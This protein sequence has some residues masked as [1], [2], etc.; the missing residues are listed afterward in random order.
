[1]KKRILLMLLP[2]VTVSLYAEISEAQ[3]RLERWLR[4]IIIEDYFPEGEPPYIP[5]RNRDALTEFRDFFIET[6]W[7][8]NQF[9]EGLI[10]A[11]TNNMTEVNWANEDKNIIAGRAIW[12]L[13]EINHPMVTN[14]FKSYIESGEHLHKVNPIPSMFTYT[15]LEPDVLAYMRTLCVQ[16][17]I[18]DCMADAVIREMLETL[19]T[20]PDALKP[21][22]TNRVAQYLYFSLHHTTQDL[23][24]QDDSLAE[25]L[26][27]YSN[28]IQRLETLNYIAATTT[29]V[30][31][32]ANVRQVI[33][34]LPSIPTNQLNDISWIAE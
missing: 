4:S 16:T 1:M 26:P 19:S 11:A 34:T 31:T 9:V 22:A 25:F 20:M 10:F 21:A 13:G 32:R 6:G 14:F 5:L 12:K 3:D 24:F 2:L 17:N 15:N 23:S 29:N 33:G 27:A 18:Y 28:S 30:M 7:T 8:T